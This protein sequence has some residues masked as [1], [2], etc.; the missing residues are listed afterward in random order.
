MT[1]RSKSMAKNF[2]IRIRLKNRL[3]LPQR[4]INASIEHPVKKFLK[5]VLSFIPEKKFF[6]LFDRTKLLFFEINFLLLSRRIKISQYFL[7]YLDGVF[8]LSFLIDQKIE[9]QPKYIIIFNPPVI[10]T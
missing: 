10:K 9:C 1:I 2:R 6:G 5:I 3:K 8:F 7:P 4:N